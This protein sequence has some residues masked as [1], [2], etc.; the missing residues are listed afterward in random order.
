MLNRNGAVDVAHSTFVDNTSGS[1]LGEGIA[2]W[3]NPVAEE[4]GGDPPPPTVFT[5]LTHS[6]VYREGGSS[7]VAVVGE[8]DADPPGPLE[9]SFENLGYN[10]IGALGD[11]VEGADG[12]L[13]P[14]TD[15]RLLPLDDYGG[16]TPVMLPNNDPE[17][18]DFDG[19]SPLIDAGN[20]EVE[21]ASEFEQRGRYFTRIFNATDAED[22]IIDIGAA[23]VQRGLFTV[24]SL[25]DETDLQFS[26]FT[27]PDTN[28]I[29][30]D[31]ENGND[32]S[33]REAIEFSSKNPELDTID[34]ADSLRTEID[35]TISAARTIL[36]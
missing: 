2:S 21:D 8:S 4:E 34:V 13:A 29:D 12:D 33:F 22:A 16:S 6:V 7:D 20:P 3:G 24:D 15:P 1:E 9:P 32:F 10:L 19:I 31:Y 26:G 17:N 30:M 5:T 14:G 18:P 11:Q 25:L 28:V 27:D 35:P 23:E 36:L